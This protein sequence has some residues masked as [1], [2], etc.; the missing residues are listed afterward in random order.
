M[1]LGH[2]SWLWS[3]TTTVL[4]ATFNKMLVQT[5][6]EKRLEGLRSVSKMLSDKNGLLDLCWLQETQ[7]E[8]S[9][10]RHNTNDMAILIM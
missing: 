7:M 5:P 10:K 6:A 1:T 9:E 8:D 3:E 2:H 4:E